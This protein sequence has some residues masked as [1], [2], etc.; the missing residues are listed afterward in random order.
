MPLLKIKKSE[1]AAV[2]LVPPWHPNFRNFERLPDVKAV[3]TSFFVNGAAITITLAVLF[4][5][6]WQEYNLHEVHLQINEWQRQIDAN[7]KASEKAVQLYKKFKDEEKKVSDVGD[8]VK[9]DFV[10]SDFVIELGQTLPENIALNSIDVHQGGAWLRGIVRGTSDEASGQASAY[11]D[12]LRANPRIA[13]KFANVSLTSLNR[14]V[15]AG[16]LDFELSLKSKTG[17]NP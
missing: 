15:K 13:S 8:F 7:E 10:L 11:I 1:R 6:G 17:A 14:G 16:E 9:N 5:F 3:R 12:Q 4:Y 2:S